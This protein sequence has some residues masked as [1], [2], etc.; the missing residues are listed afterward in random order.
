[1]FRNDGSSVHNYWVD[2]TT[3]I[4]KMVEE[5]LRLNIKWSLQE[6]NRA[7]NG[8]GKTTPNPLFKVLVVLNA[9]VCDFSLE[10][11]MFNNT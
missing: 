4:D 9:Q 3:S 7:I 10:K 1:V 8:D 11:I 6:I 5:A 2:Y